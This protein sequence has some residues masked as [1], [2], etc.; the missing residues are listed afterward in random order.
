MMTYRIAS[1][2]LTADTF[3]HPAQLDQPDWAG[4]SDN[5]PAAASALRRIMLEELLDTARLIAPSHF[6]EPFGTI[7]TDAGRVVWRPA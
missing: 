7:V 2:L 1:L 3:N 5:D 4:D 6:V